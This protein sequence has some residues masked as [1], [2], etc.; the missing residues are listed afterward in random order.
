MHGNYGL[1][2]LVWTRSGW[3]GVCLDRFVEYCRARGKDQD[4][5]HMAFTCLLDLFHVSHEPFPLGPSVVTLMLCCFFYVNFFGSLVLFLF[6][7]TL[8]Q[9]YV[10]CFQIFFLLFFFLLFSHN[11]F[12]ILLAGEFSLHFFNK[13]T[14]YMT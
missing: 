5:Y 4:F 1:S 10:I 2:K 3:E 12:I 7:F 11:K 6:F 8:S 9:S 14:K 13:F